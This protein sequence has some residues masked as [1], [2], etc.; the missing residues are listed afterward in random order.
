VTL[1]AVDVGFGPDVEHESLVT[2]ELH[3]LRA[4]H[5]ARQIF[6]ADGRGEARRS[7][8]VLLDDVAVMALANPV[9]LVEGIL[10]AATLAPGFGLPETGKSHILTI[11]L[12]LSV[13]TGRPWYGAPIVTPG[14]VVAIV[15][16]GAAGIKTR[17]KAWKTARHFALDVP[18]G[19]HIVPH[20]ID[21]SN[22]ADVT[23]FIDA[24]QPLEPRLVI[25]DT[26]PRCMGDLEENDASGMG[27]AIRACDRIKDATGATVMPITHSG[28]DGKDIRGSSALRGAADTLIRITREDDLI[29][30]TCDKSKDAPA[31][32]DIR[33]K[34]VPVPGTDGVVPRMLHEVLAS[35]R[36]TITQYRV[37]SALHEMF[38]DK[39]ATSAE[40][41]KVATQTMSDASYYRARRA[42]EDAG[43]VTTQGQRYFARPVRPDLFPDGDL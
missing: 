22:P 2:R 4:R 27:L 37:W 12:G 29:L 24:V 17:I 21:L 3:A 19:Y 34:L 13:A 18:V 25:I 39:G 1:R 41:Q 5:E 8:I 28:K 30:I 15:A 35:S 10:G 23:A 36:L 7:G 40:W 26:L 9:Y 14:P 32:A 20:A 6:E 43:H 16:E 38:A 33:V 31:F 42:L 11:D